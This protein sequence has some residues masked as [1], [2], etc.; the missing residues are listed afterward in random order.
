[1]SR[2]RGRAWLPSRRA[3]NRLIMTILITRKGMTITAND[4]NGRTARLHDCRSVRNAVALE[5]KLNTDQAFADQWARMVDL[6]FQ[7]AKSFR[8]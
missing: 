4:E 6:G 2:Q 8:P 5:H 7:P 1:M 3:P